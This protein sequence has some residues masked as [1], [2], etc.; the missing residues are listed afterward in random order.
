M[1]SA[2]TLGRVARESKVERV[3]GGCR[4]PKI[5][6]ATTGSRWPRCDK[7]QTGSK[8]SACPRTRRGCPLIVGPK[9]PHHHANA[10]RY[11]CGVTDTTFPHLAIPRPHRSG[12]CAARR[13]GG[14][15][16]T[17]S[18]YTMV[19]ALCQASYADWSI[20]GVKSVHTALRLAD[21]ILTI[22]SEQG[23][24]FTF[25]SGISCGGLG[26][27]GQAEQGIPLLLRGLAIHRATV[28]QIAGAVLHDDARGGL[29]TSRGPAE[30]TRQPRRGSRAG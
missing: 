25:G 7:L 16:T 2:L 17:V 14:R 18:P 1:R 4:R 21:E 12:A 24:F 28:R 6:Q 23:F 20:A 22:S 27:V 13:G 15:G 29:W 10:L 11:A 26:A 30:G 3:P 8:S 9:I 5:R 19:F